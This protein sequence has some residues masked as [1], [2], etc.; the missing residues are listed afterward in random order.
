L[1]FS[2]TFSLG[3]LSCNKIFKQLFLYSEEQIL[4][5]PLYICMSCANALISLNSLVEVSPMGF[6]STDKIPK[7][8]ASSQPPAEA[9]RGGLFSMR[10]RKIMKS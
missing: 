3:L 1:R 6:K 2:Y 9:F 5:A 10:F 4:P 8:T 7:M